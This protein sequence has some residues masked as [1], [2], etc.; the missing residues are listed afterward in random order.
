MPQPAHP[1]FELC[2]PSPLGSDLGHEVEDASQTINELAA[3]C[4]E[5]LLRGA[6]GF[7]GAAQNAVLEA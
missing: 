1:G 2:P 5:L 7:R 6:S 3:R 4:A